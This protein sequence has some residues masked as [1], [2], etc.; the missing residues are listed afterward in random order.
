MKSCLT[1]SV[2]LSS[3]HIQFTKATL[4]V[5]MEI[6]S[7]FLYILSE[8]WK[9]INVN[10]IT[11]V[12]LCN[13]YSGDYIHILNDVNQCISSTIYLERRVFCG[14]PPCR[15]LLFYAGLV[16]RL[17]VYMSSS[18]VYVYLVI[19]VVSPHI[20][21]LVLY[22]V[23]QVCVVFSLAPLQYVNCLSSF[24]FLFVLCALS[25]CIK[26]FSLQFKLSLFMRCLAT[27]FLL[28]VD[29]LRLA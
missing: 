3:F 29:K 13:I 21:L 6:Y 4:K 15:S 2:Q 19:T 23:F 25:F 11:W 24:L 14:P 9:C 7:S 17:S 1:K 16:F 8:L 26:S 20:F 10:K 18:L 12:T 27:M 28:K 5:Q 22:F